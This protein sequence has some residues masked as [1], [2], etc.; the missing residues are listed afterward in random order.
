MDADDSTHKKR[1]IWYKTF[2]SALNLDMD[3]EILI[4]FVVFVITKVI[5]F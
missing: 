2:I 5:S 4:I 3:V 1:N